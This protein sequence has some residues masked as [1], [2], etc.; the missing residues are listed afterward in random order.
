MP[1]NP[2]GS[3]AYNQGIGSATAGQQLNTAMTMVVPSS[4]NLTG[5]VATWEVL[6]MDGFVWSSGDC[7]AVSSIVSQVN[8]NALQL[9]ADSTIVLPANMVANPN[10]S[11]YQ[12]RYTVNANGQS[13]V[14]FEQFVVM[15]PVAS[16]T[17][18][19]DLVE[20][21]S[22][23]FQAKLI[24]PHQAADV[25]CSI[26][27]GN[28]PITPEKPAEDEIPVQGGLLYK[29]LFK[30]GCHPSKL[31]SVE[32][33]SLMWTYRDAFETTNT[34]R[35]ELFM[36][37]PTMLD[38]V[39]EIQSFINRAYVDSGVSP[40]T[41]FGSADCMRSLRYARDQF[42]AAGITTN[43][44]MTQAQGQFRHFWVTLACVQACR[45]QYMAEG[46]KAFDYGGQNV[47]LNVDRTQYWDSLANTLEQ[48][49]REDL[50]HFKQ[51]LARR[52]NFQGNGAYTGLVSA[53]QV[54]ITIHA[55]SPFRT[56]LWS[57]TGAF[58]SPNLWV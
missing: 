15:P 49:I 45:A 41:T 57:P 47:T 5:A 6:D 54:G 31:V 28:G 12:V 56:S 21:Y 40:G 7:G 2:Q 1:L 42:N 26:W 9:T 34:E 20:M 3:G 36:V 46:M 39:R 33:Y 10:G 35:A 27:S 23:E 32:P 30:A 53:G 25:K 51:Q 48:S 24:L 29:V 50:V 43:F 14:S 4:M 52:G 22:P 37:N 17:G 8:P 55:A 16:F 58:S 19:V 18:A 38:A 11:R 13:L 44:D